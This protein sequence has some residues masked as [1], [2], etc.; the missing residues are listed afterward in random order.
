MSDVTT[1]SSAVFGFLVTLSF[2]IRKHKV[3]KSSGWNLIHSTQAPHEEAEVPRHIP[4]PIDASVLPWAPLANGT[5]V[6][7]RDC[8][9]QQHL[10]FSGSGL[11]LEVKLV[12]FFF[13]RSIG[14]KLSD[15]FYDKRTILSQ[16]LHAYR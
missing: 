15:D 3:P 7:R 10:L 1:L 12:F 6:T 13:S 8:G 5:P 14:R 11:D 4:L 2:I 16:G 9:T